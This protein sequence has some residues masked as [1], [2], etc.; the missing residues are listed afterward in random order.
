MPQLT[1]FKPDNSCVDVLIISEELYK[2]LYKF[3]QLFELEF[4]DLDALKKIK[5]HALSVVPQNKNRTNFR[6]IQKIASNSF[7]CF[8]ELIDVIVRLENLENSD[9]LLIYLS[10]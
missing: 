1:I 8:D 9:F 3:S 7:D 10:K 5:G 4:L 6:E 2:A